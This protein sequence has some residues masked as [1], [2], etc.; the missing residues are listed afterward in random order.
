MRFLIATTFTDGLAKLTGDEQK[1][2]KTTVFDLQTDPSQPGLSFHR[3]DKSKDPNFWSVRVSRDVR[4]IVHKRAESTVLC[5]VD[6]HDDAYKWAERRKLEIHPKTGA[7][8]LVEV[9]E[10]VREIIVPRAVEAAP[11]VQTKPLL[12][13]GISDDALLGYGVPDEWLTDVRAADEDSV[14]DLAEHLPAEAAEALLVLAVGGT[15]QTALASSAPPSFEPSDLPMVAEAPAEYVETPSSDPF[16]HPDAQ[17]R[18]RVMHDVAELE[19]ALN[20]PWEKWAVFLHPVQRQIVEKDFSGP[21]RVFG[22]AGTGKTIV[23]LHRAV[24]LARNNP[25]ARVLLTTFSDTLADA[26]R[27]KLTRLIHNEP[28][29]A[30]R[31][32]VEAIDAVG[33][34]LYRSQ[35]EPPR[36]A[37]REETEE[38]LVNAAGGAEKGDFNPR[39]L[40]GE[41]ENVVDAWQLD[42]WEAYRDVRRL[43]R[44]T[45]LPAERRAVLWAVF[46]KVRT[47][48][49]NRG[50]LTKAGMFG[51]LAENL[52]DRPHP[53]FEFA[54]VDEAQDVSVAQLRFL[55]AL[56]G[57]RPNGLF[58]A[59][60]L[61]QRIFQTP[62]SWK[63]IGVEVRGRSQ[64]LKLNYRTSHQIR[65]KA[66]RLL[67]PEVADVDGNVEDRRG[68]VSAFNG[69]DPTVRVFE[70]Q[71]K[72]TDAVAQWLRQRE[73]EGVSAREMG[74][75]VRSATQL[76]RARQAVTEAGLRSQ[77]LDEQA[78][79]GADA[80]SVCTMHLAKGLEF[81]A[82][83]VMACDDEILPLQ[84]RIENVTDDA[85]LEEVY[86]TERHLLYVACTR[87][88]DYLMI[89]GV[90]PASEFLDDFLLQP[91]GA[92]A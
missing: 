22:T 45:R 79:P 88:R 47:E 59:G 89:T 6:H 31:V 83:S 41:W 32:E 53:P 76:D 24:H 49:Q 44:K 28:R 26:L 39:F 56:G 71:D 81:R 33:E 7:A 70:T 64:I 78:G 27:A 48:I 61:G 46:E 25:D 23:A 29:L 5:Y 17:R 77:V 52:K 50:W 2:A 91:S 8:Q 62:F 90:E 3:V 37:T 73:K 87:A 72:E 43:G 82:V 9:R 51:L 86:D 12:F 92:V 54:V 19:R 58:F 42:T 36:I 14:L 20:Y 40:Q 66:D 35:F 63:A 13:G 38:L 85:D 75:F 1:A 16:E 60:D 65:V 80:V 11:E 18:F 4:I 57:D 74:V 67:G 15:P 69:P 34:R 55:A 68:A 84:D 21:A 30:E 10:T